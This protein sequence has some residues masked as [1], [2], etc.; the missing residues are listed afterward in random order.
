MNED[1]NKATEEMIATASGYKLFHFIGQLKKNIGSL[2]WESTSR[3]M[4]LCFARAKELNFNRFGDWDQA[5]VEVNH[6]PEPREFESQSLLPVLGYP[7]QLIVGK[8]KMVM[9]SNGKLNKAY[10]R[11]FGEG[12]IS[13][14]TAKKIFN[15]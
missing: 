15:S 8:R 3:F 7:C 5:I 4:K 12:S 1:K 13:V 2:G 6:M 14:A 9:I 10:I 11:D